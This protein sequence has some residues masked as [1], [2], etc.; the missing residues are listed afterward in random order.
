MHPALPLP[1]AE[2]ARGDGPR[3]RRVHEPMQPAYA[4]AEAPNKRTVTIEQ[5]F[6][7]RRRAVPTV[8]K[9]RE[10][11]CDTCGSRCTRDQDGQLEFGHKY[12]CPERPDELPAGGAGGGAWHDGDTDE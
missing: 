1:S 11:Q 9:D 12:G 2:L 6:E 3:A 4:D 7:Q 5:Q 10:F 8:E